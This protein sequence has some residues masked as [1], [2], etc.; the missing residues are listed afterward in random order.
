MLKDY[1]D[2]T[3]PFLNVKLGVQ[4]VGTTMAFCISEED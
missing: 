2:L 3:M 1:F 4:G